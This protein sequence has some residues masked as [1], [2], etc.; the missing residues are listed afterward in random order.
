[1]FDPA[2]DSIKL[3]MLYVS[4]G[5]ESPVVA[6]VS[7]GRMPAVGEDEREEVRLFY[8]VGDAGDAATGDWGEW[9]R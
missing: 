8:V 6:L 1:M 7:A 9:E 4:K 2:H 5:L 3:M